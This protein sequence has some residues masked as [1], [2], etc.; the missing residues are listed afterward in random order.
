MME[1]EKA[2]IASLNLRGEVF[3]IYVDP[4]L[5]YDFKTGKKKDFSGV[6]VVDEIFKDARKGERQSDEK[7]R[8][9]FGTID[10][11]EIAKK[12]VL[13]GNVPLTTRQR[14]K[15]IE[16]KKRK[17]IA[18]ISREAVDPRTNAPHPQQR[19]EKAMEEAKIR[20]D[21]FKEAEEQVNDIINQLRLHLPM[22]FE[23]VKIAVKIPGD[24][25]QKIYGKIKEFNF[26]QS[27]WLSDG[28]FAFVVEIPRGMLTEFFDKINQITS[29]RAVVKEIEKK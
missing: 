24:I 7:L 11:N 4:E 18:I 8:K 20:I 27:E 9:F 5:A 17:I 15:L 25:A 22:K 28:S 19:I 26:E 14:E 12:I 13:E 29:G 3:E 23:K 10:V 16:E 1:I 6:L 2:V 21:P